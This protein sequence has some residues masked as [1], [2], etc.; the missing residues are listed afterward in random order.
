MEKLFNLR[1]LLSLLVLSITMLSI[2]AQNADTTEAN[3]DTTEAVSNVPK[4]IFMLQY[5]FIDLGHAKESGFYGF[6]DLLSLYKQGE[7]HVCLS[8]GVSANYG[9]VKVDDGVILM[10]VGPAYRVDVSKAVSVS[11]P[12]ELTCSF[13]SVK[14]YDENKK[15]F[16][17]KDKV[18][19][20]GQLGIN[21]IYMPGKIGAFLGPQFSFDKESC[22]VGACVGV[23]F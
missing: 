13:G 10:H 14:S 6:K 22:T 7:N 23:C 17:R 3:T 16:K 12:L 4:G 19:W 18:F 9:I 8:F 20:G 5:Q 21:L 15:E 2:S 11:V 1:R